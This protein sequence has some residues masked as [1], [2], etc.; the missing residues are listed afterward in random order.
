MNLNVK[1]AVQLVGI[2]GN[3]VLLTNFENGNK[4]A[5][6][7]LATNEVY[8]NAKGE[9]VKHTDWHKLIAWGR[10]AEDIAG[11][12][13]KGNE[14][15]VYGKIAYRSYVDTQG[16][17]KYIS[18]IIVNEFLKIQKKASVPAETRPF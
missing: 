5:S 11:Y 8:T 15:A 12:V 2:V 6:C 17:T 14:I 3:D 13:T 16:T 10:V 9:K 18:E 7:I 1:N 4:K